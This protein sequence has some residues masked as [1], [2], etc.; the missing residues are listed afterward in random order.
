M[1]VAREASAGSAS[2]RRPLLPFV[3][4]HLVWGI[5]AAILLVCSLA[6][7]HF[8][9]LGIFLNIALHATFVGLLA[10]GLSF[11]IVAGHMDLSIESV[12]AF[13]AMVAAWLTAARGSPLGIQLPTALTLLVVLAFGALAG[14][15]NA[16]LVVRF[17][18]NAFIVTLAT[19]IAIRGLG[20]ILTGGRSMYGLP[21]GFRA[22]GS[23]DLLG[24]P[25]LI[26]ILITTYLAFGAI[27][28]RTR[29][30]RWVYLVGGNPVAPFRAG[31]DVDR[32]LYKVFVLS[33]VLAAFAGFLLAART[34]GA[35]PNLGLGM[36]F[37]AF[38]AVVIGGV[39]LRGGVGG[40]SGVFAGVLL[41]ST[42]DTAINVMGLEASYMQVIRGALMLLAVLLDSVKQS[43]QR[44]WA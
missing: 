17:R 8:F 4:D 2:G 29:F 39:S 1:A 23:A 30:G 16:V 26:W 32:V 34:N 21:D 42:I 15:F 37:E 41:L 13:A 43:V 6:I 36:L 11:C 20:L 40:L 35:T 12:M 9:Q 5:L 22:V 31:I 7:P 10:V 38:A 18:I 25:L 3:L 28:R 14:L 33:G 24:V 19:Y 27:L 44:R